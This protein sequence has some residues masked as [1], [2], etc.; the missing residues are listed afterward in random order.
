MCGDDFCVLKVK[1][2]KN[3]EILDCI[4]PMFV[5]LFIF[6]RREV[7]MYGQGMPFWGLPCKVGIRLCAAVILEKIWKTC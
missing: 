6:L 2:K 3:V 5:L 7:V 4:P 1:L